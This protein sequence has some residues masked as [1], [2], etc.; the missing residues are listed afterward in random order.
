MTSVFHL[1]MKMIV[2]T[3]MEQ[4]Y[5]ANAFINDILVAPF[6]AMMLTT[7]SNVIMMSKQNPH[8]SRCSDRDIEQL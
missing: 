5:Q 4:T 7:Y 1:S 3:M 8:Y 6:E 2:I